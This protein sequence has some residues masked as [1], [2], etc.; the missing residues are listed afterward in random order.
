MHY[1]DAHTVVLMGAEVMSRQQEV[2]AAAACELTEQIAK[3]QLASKQALKQVSPGTARKMRQTLAQL[4]CA[5]A[6]C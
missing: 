3:Q 5:Y 6:I 4:R 2:A 1:N